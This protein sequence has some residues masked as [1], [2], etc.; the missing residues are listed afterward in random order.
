MDN[1]TTP[2]A[3]NA[4]ALMEEIFPGWTKDWLR[5]PATISVVYWITPPGPSGKSGGE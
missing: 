4:E 3:K 2:D 1:K 5:S